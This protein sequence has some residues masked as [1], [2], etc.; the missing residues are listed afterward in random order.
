MSGSYVDDVPYRTVGVLAPYDEI[1]E[2]IVY[3]RT[4]ADEQM[5]ALDTAIRNLE[6][7]IGTYDPDFEDVTAEIPALIPPSF[8]TAPTLDAQLNENWPTNNT[9]EPAIRDISPDFSFVDPTAPDPL[10]P[11]FDYTHGVYASD[12]WSELVATIR[13]TLLNGGTGLS[14]LVYGL[15]IDRNREA[16]RIAEER[17]RQ[18]TYDAVGSRGF[19]LPGGMVTAAILEI[20]KE[21]LA[22]DLDAVN[23]VTIKDFELA[24]ANSRFAKELAARMEEIQRTAY[25]NEEQRLFEIAKVSQELVIAIYEQNVK[26]YIAQWEG[27]KIKLE[28]IRIEVESLISLNEASIKIYLGQ[29]EA[30]KTEVEAIAAENKSKT[31][32]T[33]AEADIYKTVV[34][35][36]AIEF[37][38]QVEEIKVAL[39]QYRLELFEVLEKEKINLD[40]YTSSSSLA[41]RVG[42]SIATIASQSVASAL[43]AINTGMNVGYSGSESLSYGSSLSNS[44]SESHSYEDA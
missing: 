3:T 23:S 26:I 5:A 19:D 41:E 27:V 22:K 8:P 28:A 29:I 4:F 36:V 24:D 35:S 7:I 17:V 30:Y 6:T 10:N 44:L 32:I 34:E 20:E 38:A 42:E 25:E 1:V 40:A 16:R 39:E 15:I 18:Q 31:E 12:L 33:Q 11:S 2:T 43:G 37:S 13:D 21:I 9:N 14:D